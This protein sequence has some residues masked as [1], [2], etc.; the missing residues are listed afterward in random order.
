MAM[1]HEKLYQSDDLGRIDFGEYIRSL[2]IGLCNTYGL[3]S[4][5]VDLKI[6]VENGLM[7]VDIEIPC[8]VMLQ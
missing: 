5:G 3:E 6:D 2:A 7:G 1:V 8:G 4:R